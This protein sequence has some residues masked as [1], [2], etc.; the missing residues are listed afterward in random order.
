MNQALLPALAAK[1][2]GSAIGEHLVDVHVALR[3]RAGLPHD[4]WEFV[5]VF[6]SEHLVGGL[7]NRL[8][9]PVLEK[10]QLGVDQCGAFLDQRQGID[11]WQRHALAGDAEE[12]PAALGLRA[13]KAFSRYLDRSEAVLLGALAAHSG[14]NVTS[15][16]H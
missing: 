15:A 8:R 6:S 14:N 2:L 5:V 1:D 13:P 9:F 4:E 16:F 3:A 10:T 12:A 11:H 7:D